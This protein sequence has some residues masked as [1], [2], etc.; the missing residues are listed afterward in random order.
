[1]LLCI[2]GTP[3]P[4]LDVRPRTKPMAKK[5]TEA[6]DPPSPYPMGT[7]EPCMCCGSELWLFTLLIGLYDKEVQ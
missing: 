5:H 2:L 4:K 3:G 1:M 7:P 6:N